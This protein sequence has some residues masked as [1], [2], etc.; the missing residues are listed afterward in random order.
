LPAVEFIPGKPP[1]GLAVPIAATTLNFTSIPGDWDGEW[2]PTP[3]RQFWITLAGEALV[4]TS[5]AERRHLTA[6]AVV[7]LENCTGRGHNTRVVGE[8]SYYGVLI[9]LPEGE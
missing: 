6:G 1:I 3:R 7:L 2:H 8:T 4:T 5:D 9:A